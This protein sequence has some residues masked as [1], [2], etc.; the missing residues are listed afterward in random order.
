M[1]QVVVFTLAGFIWWG[2]AAF[3]QSPASNQSQPPSPPA[4]QTQSQSSSQKSTRPQ[5]SDN[6]DDILNSPMTPPRSD[7]SAATPAKKNTAPEEFPFPEEEEHG[8]YSSSKD[9]QG[10]IGPPPGDS[11][12]PG[13]DIKG[14][15]SDDVMETKPWNP[16]EADK[17][18]EV[19]TFYFK[20]GNYKAAEAR[21]RD[22]LAWQDN[23]AEA[24]YRLA[25]TLQKE[26]KL[27]EARQYYEG[28][29][30]ILPHGQFAGDSRKELDK[31]DASV[32]GGKTP[33]KKSATS[34]SL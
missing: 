19:G 32:E 17:D 25:S 30:A 8:N 33:P 14:E 11:A 4:S 3:G 31:L 24:M 23:D 12:H 26:G 27:P 34:P 22:A 7:E 13:T 5:P 28:Y 18:V 6:P 16:H 10:D 29:L 21:F 20:R 1:K 2:T 9:T 15:P